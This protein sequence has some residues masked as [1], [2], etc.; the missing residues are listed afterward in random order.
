MLIYSIIIFVIQSSFMDLVLDI[1]NTRIKY[2]IFKDSVL[3]N[4]GYSRGNE[5]EKTL[6]AF[7][8]RINKLLIST[9]K[10][11]LGSQEIM[12]KKVCSN[13]YILSS[14]LQ[15]PFNIKYQT[16]QTLGS[17]R[18]A[19]AAGALLSFPK[20]PVLIIDIGTCMT[21]D[22]VNAESDYLGG[23]I[24]P[25]LRMRLKALHNFTGKLP[26]IE[27]EQ[28][29]DF[30]GL[31]TND[32]ILSGVINGMLMEIDGIIDCY[33]LRYPMVKTILTGG[34]MSFFD[35]KLKNSIFAEADILLMGMHF[36]LE[37]NT[38]EIN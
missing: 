38:N 15:M 16:P 34:D 11:I 1:G 20:N 26:L 18:L 4:K 19:L 10:P 32:S 33:K 8:G 36:I 37:Y 21:F 28:P 27:P 22:F 23:A 9:V 30:I 12:F 17:D 3:I 31:N 25:G 5:L 13:L 7:V 35:L 14:N 6:K 24:S 2:A 29:Q